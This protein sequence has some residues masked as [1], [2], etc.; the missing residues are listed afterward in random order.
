MQLEDM[1]K[2]STSYDSKSKSFG[3]VQK[4]SFFFGENVDC[5]TSS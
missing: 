2:K 3:V 5:G 4:L 1:N